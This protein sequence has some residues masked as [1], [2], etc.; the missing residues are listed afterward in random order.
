M[1]P[2]IVR[3]CKDEMRLGVCHFL[4]GM[5]RIMTGH[6]SLAE[7]SLPKVRTFTQLISAD[8]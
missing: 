8:V 3:Q 6:H 1:A 2:D 5:R 7:S 4:C